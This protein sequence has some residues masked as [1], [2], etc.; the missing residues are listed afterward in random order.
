MPYLLYPQGNSPQYPL[1]RMVGKQ[2]ASLNMVQRE[3]IPF[4]PLPGIE[5]CSSSLQQSQYTDWATPAESYVDGTKNM[6]D[7]NDMNLPSPICTQ[8][9]LTVF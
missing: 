1:D 4:L 8:L 5:P 6:T 2:Q 7:I 9:V 3:N